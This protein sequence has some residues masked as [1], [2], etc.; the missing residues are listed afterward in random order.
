MFASLEN[1]VVNQLR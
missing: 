1:I